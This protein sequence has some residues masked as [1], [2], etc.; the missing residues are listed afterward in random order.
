[1]IYIT[2]KMIHNSV[3]Y[4]YMKLL[5]KYSYYVALIQA[6]IATFSSLFLSEI[7]HWTPCILCWYQRILMYPLIL[8]ISVGIVRKDKNLPFYVLPMSILGA[9]I[10]LYHYLLQWGMFPE[11]LAP[12][13]AGISCASKVHMWYGFIT[14]PFLALVAFAVI[15][16]LMYI[17]LKGKK[18]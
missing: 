9:L 2:G 13:T 11:T 12:C 14:I 6:I 3:Y 7:L 1:M 4:R 17:S 8:I 18:L 5:A 10:A 16:M 15:S